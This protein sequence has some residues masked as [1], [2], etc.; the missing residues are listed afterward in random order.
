MFF[1]WIIELLAEL[2]LE[3][4]A[5]I[6]DDTLWGTEWRDPLV[7]NLRV[8]VSGEL[9]VDGTGNGETTGHVHHVQKGKRSALIIVQREQVDNNA[10][11]EIAIDADS[12]W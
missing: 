3:L 8:D 7:E 11:V 2:A 1:R 4:S 6:E 5:S 9:R 10:V 12:R